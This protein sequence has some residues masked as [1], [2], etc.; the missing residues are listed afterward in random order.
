MSV[1]DQIYPVPGFDAT[2]Q[3]QM[4]RS[5]WRPW[6]ETFKTVLDII[7]QAVPDHPKVPRWMLYCSEEIV[8]IDGH[9]L[10]FAS[11]EDLNS[12][13]NHHHRS[14]LSS[15]TIFSLITTHQVPRF[16]WWEGATLTILPGMGQLP[17]FCL[18]HLIGQHQY[19]LLTLDLGHGLGFTMFHLQIPGVAA[20]G[21]VRPPFPQLPH[22][23]MQRT[24][25]QSLVVRRISNACS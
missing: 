8:D 23:I 10:Y 19:N 20:F 16:L 17:S 18:L 11:N 6:S 5:I 13:I 9:L 2:T 7:P 15:P 21:Q 22:R 3:K 14:H 1:A 4:L 25:D 12:H 24:V